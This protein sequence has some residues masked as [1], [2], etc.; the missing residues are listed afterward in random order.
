MIIL[1][2]PTGAAYMPWHP[3]L[4]TPYYIYKEKTIGLA[5][6]LHRL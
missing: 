1:D 4:L 2:L 6:G 5:T 3:P